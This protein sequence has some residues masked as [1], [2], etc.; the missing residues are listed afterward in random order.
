MF[1]LSISDYH[2][3]RTCSELRALLQAIYDLERQRYLVE[4][5]QVWSHFP[6]HDK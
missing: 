1:L 6:I 3:A 2:Q 4:L 5:K